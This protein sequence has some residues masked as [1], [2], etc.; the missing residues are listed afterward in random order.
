MRSP[1]RW[2][3]AV[4]A[5]VL[6]FAAEAAEPAFQEVVV[7][8]GD[9][10]WA[11]ANAYL[12]DP[13]RWDELLKYN[14][15]LASRDPTVALTGMTLRVPV[16]MIK[17]DLRTAWLYDRHNKVLY[18]R[19]GVGDW[20][21]TGSDMDLFGNDAVRTL[22]SSRAKVRFLN[23]DLL[24]LDPNSMAVFKPDDKDYDVEL[25]AG[26]LFVGSRSKVATPST[27]ITP[28]GQDSKYSAKVRPDLSTLVEV[29]TG[30]VGVE[31][32][33]KTVD[34]GAGMA[35]EVKIGLAPGVPMAIPD[36]PDFQ[37]RAADFD[38]AFRKTRAPIAAPP[39]P[40][41][42]RP[43]GA[44]DLGANRSDLKSLKVG[45]PVSAYHIQVSRTEDFAAVVL[46][47]VFDADP[48]VDFKAAGLPPG[49]YWVRVAAIDLL[50]AKGT[51]SAP[52]FYTWTGAARAPEAGRNPAR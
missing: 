48:G 8:P 37:A 20:K 33:G 18:R 26:G 21:A 35:T 5:G 52:K 17:E 49:Q 4:L 9:T 6:C 29:Y 12:K 22:D 38:A 25:K 2:T 11:I 50:G 41:A 10:L 44:S 24:S 16:G 13:A 46:D 3:A 45:V 30:K 34:V 43:G 31:A 28:R 1:R 40:A 32:A 7:K 36:M 14:N 27:V 42:R 23:K 51:F 39:A 19:R 47:R 15:Q